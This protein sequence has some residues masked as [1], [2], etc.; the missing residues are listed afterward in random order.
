MSTQ[1]PTRQ[2]NRQARRQA[3]QTAT[4]KQRLGTYTDTRGRPREIVCHPGAHGSTLVIDRAANTRTDQRLVAHM[5]A[6]EP[7]ENARIL[8]AL[9][10]NDYQGR[11]CR[12][13]GPT[14]FHQPPLIAQKIEHTTTPPPEEIIDRDGCV[15]RLGT[16]PNCD[17]PTPLGWWRLCPN[18]DRPEPVSVRE[19]IGRLESYEPARTMTLQAIATAKQGVSVRALQTQL[20]SVCNGKK[21]LNRA[22][23]E[24]VL[25]AIEKDNTSMNEIAIH[26]G[27]VRRE[28]NGRENGETSWLARRIGQLPEACG[29]TPSPWIR[30]DTLALIAR[31]GLGINPCEVELE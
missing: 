25:N 10:L 4:D 7:P 15:Y 12:R 14:D 20:E 5:A 31:K 18:H 24:A 16:P 2:V 17:P 19:L 13:V 27:R 21:I 23:R 11:H 28:Q 1:T 22:L 8:C 26:C 9:Y 6:D 29:S 30:S 3:C